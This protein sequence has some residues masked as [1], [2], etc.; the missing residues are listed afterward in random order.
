MPIPIKEQPECAEIVVSKIW[1]ITKFVRADQPS[2]NN[3]YNDVISKI[4]ESGE[5]HG[6][7]VAT[8][9]T[10]TEKNAGIQT[11]LLIKYNNDIAKNLLEITRDKGGCCSIF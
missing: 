7:F 3:I 9:N 8:A 5:H 4:S 1:S 11:C 6:F 10:S 2:W